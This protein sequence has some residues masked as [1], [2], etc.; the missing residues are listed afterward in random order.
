MG[1][2]ER[3]GAKGFTKY[4]WYPGNVEDWKR[5]GIAIGTGALLT[6]AVYMV[7]DSL[8]WAVVVG[9]TV[10]ACMTGYA[11]GNKDASSFDG[12]G[13]LR[14]TVAGKAL[15]RATAKG[16][17]AA[18]AAVLVARVS[19]TD[20]WTG[21]VL[22]IVPG[23]AGAIAHQFSMIHVKFVEAKQAEAAAVQEAT[24]VPVG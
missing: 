20:D 23:I 11:L 19:P 8:M 18:A 10:T 14:S 13:N 21:W 24:P 2:I 1:R 16:F 15:W 12:L 5:A 6:L 3:A 17:G 4:V 9:C 7:A 22:P